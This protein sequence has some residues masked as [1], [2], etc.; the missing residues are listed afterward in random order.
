MSEQPLA[1]GRTVCAAS[2]LRL[3]SAPGA[4][5]VTWAPYVVSG[6]IPATENLTARLDLTAEV[7]R[8]KRERRVRQRA[9]RTARVLRRGAH[10]LRPATV[11]TPRTVALEQ[12]LP[13]LLPSAVRIWH[14]RA[15]L[16]A[17]TVALGCENGTPTPSSRLPTKQRAVRL[18]ACTTWR[19]VGARAAMPK[20]SVKTLIWQS[21]WLGMAESTW[22]ISS[23]TPTLA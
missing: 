10:R 16:S 14:A 22:F 3:R 15:G 12:G 6:R 20:S 17:M 7:M 18:R 1:L 19:L 9:M 21:A 23:T 4:T 8:H 11:S 13:P 5:P 2:C